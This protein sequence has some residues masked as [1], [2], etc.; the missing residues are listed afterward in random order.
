[1]AQRLARWAHNPEDTGSKPVVGISLNGF[2]YNLIAIN[3][4]FFTT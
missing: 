1:M 2:I 4:I 3:K